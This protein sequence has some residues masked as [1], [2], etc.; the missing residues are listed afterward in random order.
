MDRLDDRLVPLGNNKDDETSEVLQDTTCA[1]KVAASGDIC[2]AC[3]Q[4]RL[5]FDGMLNL[6]CPHCGVVFNGGG[7]F[8]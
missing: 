7:A 6:A 5:D 2:P 3:G 8:T 1:G 4:A